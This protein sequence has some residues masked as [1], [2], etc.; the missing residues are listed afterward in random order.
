MADQQASTFEKDA[1]D[2]FNKLEKA[3]KA[4]NDN[5]YVAAVLEKGLSEARALLQ[6]RKI[7]EA[8]QKYTET[9][10]LMERAEAS[11]QAEPLAWNLFWLDLAYLVALLI[12]GYVTYEWRTY[13][14]WEKFIT[15][16]A[17]TAWFGALGGVT[18]GLFGLYTH[19]QARDFD[20]KFKLWYISKPIMGG[21]FGWFVFL[22]F[23]VGL[24][25][26]Q[27]NMDHTNPLLLYVIAFLAGFSERFTIKIV[28][29]IMQVLTTWEENPTST[30]GTSPQTK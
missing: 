8:E 5:E 4:L 1:P 21:I 13:W 11:I 23:Y 25:A 9:K 3:M 2:L 7:D 15:L 18:I 30:P 6:A 14:L 26:V 19:I 12:I 17:A 22:V 24:V 20:P 29:R 28:D 10:T 16:H 27:Q